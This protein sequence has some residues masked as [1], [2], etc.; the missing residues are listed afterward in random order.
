[1][2][3]EVVADLV[4]GAGQ[5]VDDA[6]RGT[7]AA[8]SRRT[9]SPATTGG[10]PAGFTITALPAARE[11]RHAGEDREREV[12]GRDHEGDAAR[13]VEV[14]VVLAGRVAHA[15]W[16]A[17]AQHLAPVI[18]E[19]IDGLGDVGVGL[20]PGLAGLEGLERGEREG[21]PRISSAARKSTPARPAGAVSRQAGAAVR[22]AATAASASARPP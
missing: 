18:F 19:E 6:P 13:L 2:A 4:A 9:S 7:P 17:E 1:M 11:A 20:A 5:V 3:Y 12:P 14:D 8:R 15:P 16:L 10:G 21:S 22:A